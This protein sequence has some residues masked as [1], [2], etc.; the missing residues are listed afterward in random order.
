MLVLDRTMESKQVCGQGRSQWV[1]VDVGS[2]ID[3]GG[4][5]WAVAQE[6]ARLVEVLVRVLERE[7]AVRPLTSVSLLVFGRAI[8]LYR[9]GPSHSS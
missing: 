6:A 9:G 4:W 3:D 7:A 8:S 2:M 1:G 5:G